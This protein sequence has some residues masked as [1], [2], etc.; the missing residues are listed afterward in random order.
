M[1]QLD[2]NCKYPNHIYMV[3]IYKPVG[4]GLENNLKTNPWTLKLQKSLC[5]VSL[6]FLCFRFDLMDKGA[7]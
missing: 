5:E 1:K 7:V 3:C 2:I 4:K 6:K